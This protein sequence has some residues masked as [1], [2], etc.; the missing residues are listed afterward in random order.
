M[1]VKPT[2]MKVHLTTDAS[3]CERTRAAAWGAL[4]TSDRSAI[5]RGQALS[6]SFSC[7]NSIEVWAAAFGLDAAIEAGV[8][9]R[10]DHVIWQTDST[11][12]ARRLAPD[13][14]SLRARKRERRGL[15]V[16]PKPP[17]SKQH[18]SPVAMFKML[19]ETHALTLEIVRSR[20]GAMHSVD[21]LARG[22]M[23]EERSRRDGRTIEAAHLDAFEDTLQR[24]RLAWLRQEYPESFGKDATR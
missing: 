2:I 4:A 20:G 9:A 1:Q 16:G 12:A 10:G 23:I 7:V 22:Y 18:G 24:A 15:S 3:H 11:Y 5:L 14:K 13:Y 19:L 6:G 21:Q 8:I 17:L